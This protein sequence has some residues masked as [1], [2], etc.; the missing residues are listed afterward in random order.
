MA[1]ASDE[2]TNEPNADHD[3]GGERGEDGVERP[4]Q[5]ARR[6]TGGVEFE[7]DGLRGDDPPAG[8]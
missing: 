6:H 2:T 3:D 4:R 1:P 8:R 5:G 7:E